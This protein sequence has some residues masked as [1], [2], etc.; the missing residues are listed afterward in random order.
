MVEKADLLAQS[1]SK[2]GMSDVARQ[3]EG[4]VGEQCCVDV[5]QG[6]SSNANIDEIEPIL[7]SAGRPILQIWN[8][9][10]TRKPADI[11]HKFSRRRAVRDQVGEKDDELA[12]DEVDQ[13]Q[14]HAGA[15]GGKDTDGLE[16]IVDWPAVGEDALCDVRSRIQDVRTKGWGRI[17]GGGKTQKVARFLQK[18]LGVQQFG[19]DSWSV[20]WWIRRPGAS[21]EL[22]VASPWC[23]SGRRRE[24]C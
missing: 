10:Y 2:V 4:H 19:L 8:E 24:C 21:R 3:S 22:A 11:G 23:S 9:L 7:L 17:F 13:G 1:S 5:S 12:H 20:L 18:S 15:D 14:G 6:E 16:D